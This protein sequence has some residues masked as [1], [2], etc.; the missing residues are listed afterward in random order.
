MELLVE[1]QEVAIEGTII[2]VK[3]VRES[4][5]LSLKS[6]N[7]NLIRRWFLSEELLVLLLEDAV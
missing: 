4:Q 3:E 7:Q 5:E 1:I 6:Q 2:D